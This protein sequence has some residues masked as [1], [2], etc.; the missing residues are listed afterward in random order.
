[1]IILHD[2][3]WNF[4]CN[5]Y[6]EHSTVLHWWWQCSIWLWQLFDFS[7]PLR[8]CW[9]I[10]KPMNL[11][12]FVQTIV[13]V[14]W[15]FVTLSNNRERIC[16]T[17][18]W[19]KQTKFCMICLLIAFD[20]MQTIYIIFQSRGFN[21]VPWVLIADSSSFQAL[22]T[23]LDWLTLLTSTSCCFFVNFKCTRLWPR[24]WWT[25]KSQW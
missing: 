16:L 15:L 12:H 21:D 14:N 7:E 11:L 23:I 10:K 25:R 8:L 22:T 9:F 24:L 18:F 19:L 2:N 6:L 3:A 13:N 20:R 1:M 17:C 4:F 5:N